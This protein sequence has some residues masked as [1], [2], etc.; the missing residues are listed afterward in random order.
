MDYAAARHNMVENQ[1]R[2]NRVHDPAVTR[3]LAA[4]PREAF[5][6][7]AM[8]SY[9]YVDED[10]D[11]GGGRWLIEPLV[12]ARLVQAAGIQSSDVVLNVGDAT[13]YVTAV[14]ARLASFVVALESDGEWCQRAAAA[15]GG[16]GVDNTEVIQGPLDRGHPAKAPYDV[17]LFS[18]AVGEIPAAIC[19]QLGDGGRLVAVV[20]TSP[21]SGRA[22]MVVRA[23]DSFGRRDLFDASTPPLP[24]LTSKA[25]FEL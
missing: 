12:L 13:G 20:E 14:V 7:K 16:L 2:A 9:A 19:Q 15:L 11:I 5:V 24:G 8:R 21:A 17:V 3:A 4:V 6:P 10:L 23:G 22:V 1:I 25:R 18:G